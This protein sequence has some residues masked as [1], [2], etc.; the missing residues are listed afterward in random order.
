MQTELFSVA[1]IFTDNLFRI[2]DYQRGYAWTEKQ[3]IDFWNDLE[4]L[5]IEK[6]HYIGVLMLESVD[7]Q[8]YNKW[9]D[10]LWIIKSKKFSPYYVIDGQQRLTTIIIFLQSLIEFMNEEDSVNYTTKNEIRQR[11]LFESKDNGISRSYKFGYEKDNPSYEFLKTKIF[12]ESSDSHSIIEETIYTQNLI[13]A[14]NFFKER[15]GKLEKNEFENVFTKVTQNLLFNIY[16]ISEDIDV[17]VAFETLNN[18]GKPLSHLEL[19]KNRLIY[20]ST[21]L[22]VDQVER[23]Q[24]R[25]VINECWKSVYH[26]L[27]KNKE[28]PLLDNYFLQ[29]HFLLYFGKKLLLEESVKQSNYTW[30]IWHSEFYKDYLLEEVFKRKSY[31]ASYTSNSKFNVSLKSVYDYSHNLKKMV[32]VYCETLNP[33]SSDFSNYEKI[34]LEKIKRIN[35]RESITLVCAAF[36]HEERQA[37]RRDFLSTLEKIL[38]LQTISPYIRRFESFDLGEAAIELYEKEKSLSKIH[39]SM[40][41]L[42]AFA[43]SSVDFQDVMF[44]WTKRAG[45]YGWKGVKYFL[46]EYEQSLKDASKTNRE[47]LSWEEFSK[48]NYEEEYTI[49]HIYPQNPREKWK[50]G[51]SCYS[52]KQ[53]NVLKNAIGNLVPLSKPKNSALSNKGFAEKKCGRESMVG[54]IYGCYSEI[55]VA[56]ND[57]WLPKDI[58]ER[59]LKLLEFLEKRWGI[60]LGSREEKIK[61]LGL[62]F[63]DL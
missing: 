37:V 18:R 23:D 47:K 45:Y 11:Y 31:A 51:Y 28:K 4:Q 25:R 8:S 58:L 6:S 7:Q 26:Y 38:F 60:L 40:S 48:E 10:D 2:P 29:T 22:E 27:G 46:F 53:R 3:L 9:E 50:D 1:K 5:D 59:S 42:L 16:S 32:K 56:Q 39:E 12:L 19:L 61:L 35:T 55:E 14:K 21:E 44:N 34:Y 63:V 57:N 36:M 43:I 41:K 13:F 33:A 24:L 20:L 52:V 17:F 30:E 15:L 49:E 54:F 62:E